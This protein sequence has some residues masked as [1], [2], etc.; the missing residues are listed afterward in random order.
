MTATIPVFRPVHKFYDIIYSL[1]FSE[2]KGKLKT[3]RKFVEPFTVNG[4]THPV[5]NVWD[6]EV[7]GKVM[8]LRW[9]KVPFSEEGRVEMRVDFY[10]MQGGKM[11][12]VNAE[13]LASLKHD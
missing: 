10:R 9:T 12:D 11:M 1:E 2:Q 6:F 5:S 3:L 13:F 4:V 7:N 8:R